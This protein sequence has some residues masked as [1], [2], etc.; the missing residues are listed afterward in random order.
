MYFDH[1]KYPII[2]GADYINDEGEIGTLEAAEI[3]PNKNEAEIIINTNYKGRFYK[4]NYPTFT[5]Y[6]KLF[7][8]ERN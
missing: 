8:Y 3:C 2:I 6:W 4:L 5:I 7:N 1:E